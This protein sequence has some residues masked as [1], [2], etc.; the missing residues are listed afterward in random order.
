MS[1]KIKRQRQWEEVIGVIVRTLCESNDAAAREVGRVWKYAFEQVKGGEK[2]W[3]RMQESVT[4]KKLLREFLLNGDRSADTALDASFNLDDLPQA[5]MPSPEVAAALATFG[6]FLGHKKQ[7]AID[8]L[9]RLP[10][11]CALFDVPPQAF[12]DI[13]KTK[14]LSDVEQKIV[15]R[16]AKHFP[17]DPNRRNYFRNAEAAAYIQQQFRFS[18]Q[19]LSSTDVYQRG[20]DFYRQASKNDGPANTVTISNTSG[21]WNPHERLGTTEFVRRYQMRY[22]HELPFKDG[23]RSANFVDG[24][25]SPAHA[26]RRIYLFNRAGTW[27]A[28]CKARE[29]AK[30]RT[31]FDKDAAL[32]LEEVCARMTSPVGPLHLVAVN[33]FADCG[34]LPLATRI[35]HDVLMFSNRHPDRN[36]PITHAF[37]CVLESDGKLDCLINVLKTVADV[38][39]NGAGSGLQSIHPF[40]E[41]LYGKSKTI[42]AIEN[43]LKLEA[44]R[45]SLDADPAV[46][47]RSLRTGFKLD[48]EYLTP[49]MLRDEFKR[50]LG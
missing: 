48:L 37:W 28:F 23:F 32:F 3:I 45:R 13:L 6:M 34:A 30:N 20:A 27:D 24:I 41:N 42:K 4:Q 2:P 19:L 31:A 49:A 1:M 8:S 11:A 46:L 21:L 40:L 43:G 36:L 5:K 29:A 35:S 18:H 33:N 25:L 15:R 38:A 10:Y 9:G 17:A 44:I 22:P 12:G 7:C 26:C 50:N 47:L 14:K 16:V 39:L